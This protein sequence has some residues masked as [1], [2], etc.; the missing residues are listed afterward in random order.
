VQCKYRYYVNNGGLQFPT[1]TKNEF[2]CRNTVSS[3]AVSV[4][5]QHDIIILSS[6]GPH[7][8]IIESV[9]VD[10]ST[11]T[12]NLS[13]IAAYT[14][15]SSNNNYIV[16][17]VFHHHHHHHH[18]PPSLYFCYKKTVGAMVLYSLLASSKDEND[19]SPTIRESISQIDIIIIILLLLLLHF[20][21]TLLC[22]IATSTTSSKLSP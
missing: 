9:V 3:F 21:S 1:A 20:L 13:Q 11:C 7:G 10:P 19:I 18:V 17:T 12:Y 16:T 22:F 15:T 5:K 8:V 2:Y 4:E 14:H 6:H